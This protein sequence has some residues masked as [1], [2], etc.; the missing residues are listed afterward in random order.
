M[1][2]I[3]QSR[4]R[5]KPVAI[6]NIIFIIIISIIIISVI[7]AKNYVR[8]NFIYAGLILYQKLLFFIANSKRTA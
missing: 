7:I 3:P 8:H 4:N 1:R 5:V 2:K 6:I